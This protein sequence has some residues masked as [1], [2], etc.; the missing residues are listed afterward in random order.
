MAIKVACFNYKGGVGKTTWAIILT[1]IALTGNKKM[2][3]S[4][5]TV[6]AFDLDG[7]QNLTSSIS[8]LEKDSNYKDFFT[9]R[10]DQLSR[11]DFDS[12]KADWLIIDCPASFDESTLALKNADFVF[13]PVIANL[14]AVDFLL[15]IKE[16]AGNNK[17]LFQ[18]PIV[19]VGFNSASIITVNKVNQAIIDM[20][21]ST[22]VIGQ[23]PHYELITKNLFSDLK[24][25]WCVGLSATQREPFENIYVELLQRYKQLCA[26]RKDNN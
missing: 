12:V 6:V 21:F 7:Q 11:E 10:Q 18:F 25:W 9:L 14:N 16:V 20:G 23:T 1:Q 13:I 2:K 3:K 8:Y 26:M 24:K 19:K 17:E 4:K 15:R 5:E 22:S